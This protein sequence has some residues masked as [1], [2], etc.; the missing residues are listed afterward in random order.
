MGVLNPTL[1]SQ[2]A[3]EAPVQAPRE[4]NALTD[5][6]KLATGFTKALPTVTATSADRAV[7]ANFGNEIN[8]ARDLKEQG[9]PYK[10]RLENAAIAAVSTLGKNVPD[11]L[12][13]LYENVSGISF[14]SLGA[15]D[16]YMEDKARMNMLESE[17][18]QSLYLAVKA[19][20]TGFTNEEIEDEVLSILN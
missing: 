15:D 4:Y 12:K 9:K 6:A 8:A 2:A 19:S 5:I 17:K 20:N 11:D 16:D 18:G 1:E 3:F 7:L 10:V 14:D 13:N